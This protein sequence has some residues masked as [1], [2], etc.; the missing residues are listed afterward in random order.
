MDYKFTNQLGQAVS[1]SQF[2]GQALAITFFFTRCPIP[3]FCPRLSKNFQDVSQKLATRPGGPTNW[4]LLSVSFDT[5]FDTPPVLM[6]PHNPPYYLTL[7]TRAGFTKAKD[8]LVYQHG[9]SSGRTPP[10]SSSILSR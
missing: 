4:H 5:E 10:T 9:D 1:L 7:L 3:E 8:L 2:D 6:M